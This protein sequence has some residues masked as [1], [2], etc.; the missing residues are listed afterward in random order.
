MHVSFSFYYELLMRRWT[1]LRL[2][3]GPSSHMQSILWDQV[4]T[5]LAVSAVF[6]SGFSPLYLIPDTSSSSCVLWKPWD[7]PD[8]SQSQAE[9]E[10]LVP[11]KWVTLGK[12]SALWFLGTEWRYVREVWVRGDCHAN[13][14]IIIHHAANRAPKGR[15]GTWGL[16]I[17]CLSQAAGLLGLYCCCGHELGSHPST[18]FLQQW[19]LQWP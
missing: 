12:F 4:S 18:M 16:S 7:T 8:S 13:E 9:S 11:S 3:W 15:E 10:N 6:A 19:S 5:S 17:S 1:P 14:V 2:R